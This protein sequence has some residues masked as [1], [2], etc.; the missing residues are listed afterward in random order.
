[1]VSGTIATAASGKVRV[2]LTY[3]DGKAKRTK[4]LNLTVRIARFSGSVKPAAG[5]APRRRGRP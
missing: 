1:M 5:D 4:T 3:R 2:T